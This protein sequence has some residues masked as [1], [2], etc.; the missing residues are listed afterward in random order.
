MIAIARLRRAL[1]ACCLAAGIAGAAHLSAQL[2]ADVAAELDKLLAQVAQSVGNPLERA[3]RL[4]QLGDLELRLN[5][6]G[7]ARAAFD[8]AVALRSQGTPDNRELGR[9]AL[10]QAAVARR[11][12]RP[13]D[14]EKFLALA[15]SRLRASAPVSREYVDALMAAARDD[16]ANALQYHREALAIVAKVEPGSAREAQL[17]ETMG[18]DAV[19]RQDLEAADRFYSRSLSVLHSSPQGVD[20]ARVAN[21]LAVVAAARKQ[22]DR[23]RELYDTALGIYEKVRPGSLEAAQLLNNLGILHL[24]RGD[25]SAAEALFRRALPVQ[26]A[27]KAPADQLGATHSNLALALQ[28]LG[29]LDEAAAAFQAAIDL[30][31]AQATKLELATLLMQL[32]RTDRLRGH[33]EAHAAAAR[34]AFEIRRAEAPGTLMFA[35]AAIEFGHARE[36]EQAHAEAL[37]L[38]REAVV[39]REKLA[40][41]SS[42]LAEALERVAL[43][44]AQST[45]AL[46]AQ[47]A[48]ERAIDAWARVSPRSLDHVN[49]IHELGKFLIRRGESDEGL[50]RL[51][52]SVEILER[53]DAPARIAA[54]A[55]ALTRLR[56][57]YAVPMRVH[58]DRGDAGE[59]FA[60]VD[61]LHESMRR[62][63]CADCAKTPASPFDALTSVLADGTAVIAFS[64]QPDAT[65]VFLAMRDS[66]MRVYRIEEG[67]EQL[68]DRAARFTRRVQAP[69]INAGDWSPIVNEGLALTKLL[70]GPIEP[71]IS[72]V[73]SLLIL[74]DGPLETFPFAALVRYSSGPSRWQYFIEWKPIAFAPS[75]VAAARWASANGGVPGASADVMPGV[76]AEVAAAGHTLPGGRLVTLWTPPDAGADADVFRIF[77]QRLTSQP[78]R[79]VALAAAQ[80]ETRYRP[81]RTHPAYW[82]G[83]RYYGRPSAP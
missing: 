83:Y 31:R 9:L 48:F 10:K 41:N 39:I 67:Q 1:G 55:D 22:P 33:T 36:R 23:A 38:Y 80:R 18:D 75:V 4:E 49:V 12:R 59:A 51:R 47:N 34:E 13:A 15:L 81:G 71:S 14:A 54:P 45:D 62:A 46:A 6:I 29:K 26:T 40:P 76:V 42:D 70:F 72:R 74:P 60:L 50:R 27:Q 21:A 28:A 52:E 43:M 3:D 68:A 37:A 58:A 30:R 79:A 24:N 44:T 78:S 63:R 56:A 57:F 11:D 66:A 7:A 20:Y 73:P 77:Q 69:S 82:A 61:R 53:A 35:A 65:Y 17:N 2:P 16:S 19:R 5:L 64:V 25:S 32:A 8:E